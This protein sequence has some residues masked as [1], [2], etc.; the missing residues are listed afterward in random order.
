MRKVSLKVLT[1]NE[2]SEAK[3]KTII[4]NFRD[5][6]VDTEWHKPT[7]EK[8]EKH[9]EALGFEGV[10]IFY[11]GFGSPGDGA[12]FTAE[13]I[14]FEKYN[15]GVHSLL[16]VTGKITHRYRYYFATSTNV[17]INTG[18]S[19]TDSAHQAIE[20][21]IEQLRAEIGNGIYKELQ[22]LYWELTSDEAVK[23]SL[24]A[25]ELEFTPD[26]KLFNNLLETA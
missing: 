23:E 25:N 9:L 21:E 24:Q 10:K 12:C 20:T 19:V 14:D 7:F 22:D 26:G 13:R 6:N 17:E 5:I 16:D 15:K 8:W 4:D 3:Q 18:D 2:L 1:F 11:S